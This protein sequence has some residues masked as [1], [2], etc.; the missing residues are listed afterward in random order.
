MRTPAS[1]P[2]VGHPRQ[3]RQSFS[4]QDFDVPD[5]DYQSDFPSLEPE[6]TKKEAVKGGGLVT[7][8]KGNGK[9]KREDPKTE[10]NRSHPQ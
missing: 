7:E 4:C 9:P 2:Q 6:K 1:A 5:L 3:Q 8:G 10:F